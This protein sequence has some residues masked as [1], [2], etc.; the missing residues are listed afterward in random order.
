L[1]IEVAATL[2]VW[3]F[4]A[5]A[6]GLVLAWAYSAPPIRLKQNG[7]WGNSAVGLCYEGLP[8]F[9]G[10]AIVSGSAP[11]WPIVLVALL[12]SLGAHGIMTLNDFKSIEG[13][14]RTGIASLPVQ[15]GPKRAA[16]LACV[17]MTVAQVAVV[18]LLFVWQRPWHGTAI[19]ISLVAQAALMRR[20]LKRPRELAP[21][22]NGTGVSLYVLGMLVAA[23]AVSG[24]EP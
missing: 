2:G 5:A 22:Y 8:W 13:D 16:V 1:S 21:W 4:G 3:G 19:A 14:R 20:L 18:A 24:L 12:Y 15:L 11:S 23:F 6:F 10:A 17:T 7:W 9:T